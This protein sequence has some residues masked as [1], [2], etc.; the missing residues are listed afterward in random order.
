MDSYEPVSLAILDSLNLLNRLIPKYIISKQ[1]LINVLDMFQEYFKVLEIN[2]R[3][4]FNYYNQYFDTKNYMFFN[5]HHNGKSNRYKIRF[6]EYI[7][8]NLCFLEIKHKTNN[9]QTLKSRI[10]V[11]HVDEHIYGD[12]GRFV[13]REIGLHPEDLIPALKVSYNR[14]TLLNSDIQEKITFDTDINFRNADSNIDLTEI[15]LIEIKQ[16]SLNHSSISHQL[17]KQLYLHQIAGFS[18]YCMG[19]VYTD[20]MIKY[21]RFKSKVLF[22][23]KIMQVEMDTNTVANYSL[24]NSTEFFTM[25]FKFSLNITFV[26][27]L[28]KLIYFRTR[29]NRTYLFTFF[30]SNIIIFLVCVLLNNLTLSLG[31]SF[32]IFAIFSILRFRTM[33]IPIKEMTYLF[34]S[35]SLAIINA[36]Y[37]AN[38]GIADLLFSNIIIV[39]ITFFL[40]KAWMKN[41]LMKYIVY[42]KVEL[43]KPYN[44]KL[45]LEDLI[46]RTGLAIHKFEIGKIDFLRD[47][48]EIRVYYY[49]N[50]S[51]HFISEKDDNDDD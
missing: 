16:K 7:D 8:S 34:V 50:D 40:E 5:Q 15:A 35:I 21:N 20:N 48:A 25:L 43:V 14:I 51:S 9:A 1:Y 23:N 2:G 49:C 3:R 30:I 12:A 26:F 36:L 39:M 47:I 31:F 33:S 6:R 22:I 10:K 37:N 29:K 13:T 17:L 45:L 38:I 41:E 28:I 11:Q 4:N 18:K 19:L 46:E 24:F 42:E 32:G 44:H 27:I